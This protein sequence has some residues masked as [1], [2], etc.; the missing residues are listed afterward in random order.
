MLDHIYNS[1]DQYYTEKI[2]EYGCTPKGVDWNDEKTQILRFDQLLQ[3]I[4]V[5]NFTLSDIGCGYGKLLEYL[6]GEY[7]NFNYYGYD[8]SEEMIQQAERLFIDDKKSNFI[9]IS[10]IDE[11]QKTDY[12]VASGIFNVKMK[13]DNKQWLS[14]IL[15]TIDTMDK[16]SNKGFSFNCLTKYSDEEYMRKD[17]YYADPLFLFDYCKRKFSRNVSLLH[18]YDLYEF[19]LLVQKGE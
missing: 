9:H 18:D 7:S 12:C 19:T 10:N 11:S 6:M 5:D 3:V 16:K 15:K 17:L 4:K 14:Y 2:Q 8:L 1:I 13:Y